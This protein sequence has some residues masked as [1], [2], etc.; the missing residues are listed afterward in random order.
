ME[1]PLPGGGCGSPLSAGASGPR[2]PVTRRPGGRSA[3]PPPFSDPR[4]HRATAP[5]RHR[6]RALP[7]RAGAGPVPTP[8]SSFSLGRAG[9]GPSFSKPRGAR[10]SRARE[11][12]PRG[13]G[14]EDGRAF[15]QPP[16]SRLAGPWGR[17]APTR[18]H[19]RWDA[20]AGGPRGS[21]GAREALRPQRP[22]ALA[23][24]PVS[25]SRLGPGPSPREARTARPAS[26]ALPRPPLH[27]PR[28]PGCPAGQI[29]RLDSNVKVNRSARAH[30]EAGVVCSPGRP[31]ARK[32][33]PARPWQ[34]AGAR[35]KARAPE[36]GPG[37]PG[38]ERS[39]MESRE[40]HQGGA[41]GS[42][43]EVWKVAVKAQIPGMAFSHARVHASGTLRGPISLYVPLRLEAGTTEGCPFYS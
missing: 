25:R 18:C 30:S 10:P 6:V 23:R 8:I 24:R 26:H 32:P 43:P 34:H 17:A 38:L 41:E 11:W 15:S 29:A 13:A 1:R 2:A 31:R 3:R 33:S 22:A 39:G 37:S 7:G 42:W 21:P 19:S 40:A 4:R 36:F 12:R 5:R 14:A 16:A 20:E 27:A 9:T 28:C 35:G